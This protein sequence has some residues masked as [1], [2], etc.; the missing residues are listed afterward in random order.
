M[1]LT[2]SHRVVLKIWCTDGLRKLTRKIPPRPYLKVQKWDYSHKR[3]FPGLEASSVIFHILSTLQGVGRD[4][5]H[6]Q[7]PGARGKCGISET[8]DLQNQNLIPPGTAG[9][10]MT[11]FWSTL[12]CYSADEKKMD[13][14]LG[15][16]LVWSLHVPFTSP[17]TLV[18]SHISKMCISG[19]LVCLL[20]QDEWV[21]MCVS[22][23]CDGMASESIPALCPE[24]QG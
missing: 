6:W 17:S 7:C 1:G 4:R 24:L 19:S 20:S 18:S 8:S 3:G 13:S 23:P 22:A 12:F 11:P 5:Q 10:P 16:P 21:W 9:P 2:I 14:Q 15:S